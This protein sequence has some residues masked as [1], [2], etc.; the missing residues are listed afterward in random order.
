MKKMKV[1]LNI[2]GQVRVLRGS[3]EGWR[4]A[5][6]KA[7][8]TDEDFWKVVLDVAG[9]YQGERMLAYRAAALR[10]QEGAQS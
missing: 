2:D 4:T 3:P 5:L 7:I 1:E 9:K 10:A 6:D 8:R